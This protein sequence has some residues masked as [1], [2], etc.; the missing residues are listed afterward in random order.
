MAAVLRDDLFACSGRR[1][2]RAMHA[3]SVGDS[4]G[5]LYQFRYASKLMPDLD[6]MGDYHGSEMAFVFNVRYPMHAVVTKRDEQMVA[7]FGCFWS[8][9]AHYGHPDGGD[10]AVDACRA[11][12]AA[13]PAWPSPDEGLMAM[14]VPPSADDHQIND[15][16]DQMDRIFEKYGHR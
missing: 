15:K 3:S 2:A 14:E 6:A 5:Y 7:A 1:L 16:C 10:S 8:N 11:L 12:D 13:P 9:L 4:A